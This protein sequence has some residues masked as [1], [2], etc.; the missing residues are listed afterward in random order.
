MT[1]TTNPSST[2]KVRRDIV[3][4][5]RPT[6]R[7]DRIR[8]PDPTRIGLGPTDESL[9]SMAGLARFGAF[10]RERGIDRALREFRSLKPHGGTVYPMDAQLR[11]LIDAH[12]VGETRV[13]GVE[14]LSSDPLFVRLAGGVV[15]SI[16]TLYRDLNRFDEA[17]LEKLEALMARQGLDRERLRQHDDVHVD[18]DTTVEPQFGEKEGALPGPNPR[19]HGRPSYHPVVCR[20]P[21]LDTCVGAQLR[22]G[23]RA[24]G[25][26]D[27]EVV[28][29]IVR[30]VS[31][32]LHARQ[33]L[34]VRIDAAGD[35]A[36]LFTMFQQE[37]V[38][39]V[40]KPRLTANLWE[41]ASKVEHW[42]AVDWDAF[43]DPITE[44]ADVAFERSGWREAGARV[45]VIAVRTRE[46]RAGRQL[47]LWDG[48]DWT[49][50]LYLTNSDDP[51]EEI[52]RR[53]EGRA[54][55]EPLIAEW[56]NGWGIGEA[57]CWAF[58]ANHAVLLLKLLAHNLMRRFVRRVAPHLTR[59]RASWIRRA[60]VQVPGR[61]VR[62]GRRW[63]LR[64]P[65]AC[66]LMRL[67]E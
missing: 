2:S 66:A 14:A 23:D 49:V 62:S 44:V 34:W 10:L 9:T 22:P 7:R 16:D 52:A 43:D 67:R 20:V 41:A 11:L 47:Y 56:K 60:L 59:W 35:D 8:R 15:P 29:K 3:G 12:A 42:R 38:L 5:K 19:Y 46:L 63:L 21:E 55:I 51:A 33:R 54:G 13:F 18:V 64:V 32:Q 30:R 53:Y 61:L 27:V 17:A 45:R 28:R 65:S 31:N 25:T 57:P 48:L 39:F 50:K 40:T 58:H 37:R 26:E 24:F 36:S 1:T 4:G 6:R